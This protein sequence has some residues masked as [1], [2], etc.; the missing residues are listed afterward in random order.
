MAATA[1]DLFPRFR[2][3]DG[4]P[5]GDDMEVGRDVEQALQEQWPRLAGKLLQREDA[6]IVVVQAQVAAMRFQLR[7]ADLPV[8]MTRIAQRR[9]VDLGGAEVDETAQYA[10]RLLR[11]WQLDR[12]EVV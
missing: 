5:F 8:E 2:V 9:V 12:H 4:M 10:K 7:V 1:G 6:D 11:P 3:I